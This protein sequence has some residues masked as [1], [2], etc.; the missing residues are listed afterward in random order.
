M[1]FSTTIS[2]P[3]QSPRRFVFWGLGLA[4]AVVLASALLDYGIDPYGNFGNNR[5]GVFISAEREAKPVLLRRYPHD[6]LLVG[7][8]KMGLIPAR[9]LEGFR[10]FNASFAGATA[11]EEYY[12]VEH[13]AT[14]QKLVVLEIDFL[15][16]D[17]PANKG[18]LFAPPGLEA[19]LQLL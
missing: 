9:Q 2:E 8:S 19:N 4:G 10:F 3:Q 6:A 12:C 14:H 13:F 7:N 16:S 15:Q 17:P 1:S 11:E 18:D 5:L